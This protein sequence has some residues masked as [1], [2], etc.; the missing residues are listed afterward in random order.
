MY[1]LRQTQFL[2]RISSTHRVLN[3]DVTAGLPDRSKA[4]AE[5]LSV[6]GS[7]GVHPV[8]LLFRAA[9]V[10][11]VFMVAAVVANPAHATAQDEEETSNRS[12]ES[13]TQR[14]IYSM[15]VTGKVHLQPG[16]GENA[17]LPLS[18]KGQ[19]DYQ[20]KI[21][22]AIRPISAARHYRVAL[23]DISVGRGST[24]QTLPE[25]VRYFVVESD[26]DAR[27]AK[28]QMRRPDG[29]MSA[30]HAELLELPIDS[31][32]LTALLP[33]DGLKE[34]EQSWT[35]ESD[36]LAS[37]FG[38]DAIT[39][40]ELSCRYYKN[41]G[42]VASIHVKGKLLG[43]IHGVATEIDANGALQYDKQSKSIRQ[44]TITL[45]ENRSIGQAHPGFEVTAKIEIRLQSLTG[46]RQLSD[47]I[48]ADWDLDEINDSTIRTYESKAGGLE[49]MH[50]RR[51]HIISDQRPVMVLRMVDQGD[52]LAQCNISRLEDLSKGD[53]LAMTEFQRDVR[54]AVKASS[55]QIVDA[56]VEATESGGEILRVAAAGV[57][58]DVSLNWIYYHI[59]DAEG[60]RAAMVVSVE[61]ELFERFA[62]AERV[63]VDSLEFKNREEGVPSEARRSDSDASDR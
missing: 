54:E 5:G 35:P 6:L 30:E 48:L 22:R 58:S 25:D 28:L 52:L 31:S 59:T 40:S 61:S 3:D 11:T 57:V 7:I 37:L 33:E 47:T 32:L 8:T 2:D 44:L 62:E 10:V 9:C 50:D 51:W 34:I 1:S 27:T 26:P 14:V 53:K 55:G 23:A 60:R 38:L 29:V 63:L 36:I 17:T 18:V 4:T 12:S 46:S 15:D 41:D 21:L 19:F 16:E 42:D 20:E 43:S 49:F 45:D 24:R 39:K 56:K 13:R